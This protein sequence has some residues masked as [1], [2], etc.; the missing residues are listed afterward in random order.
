MKTKKILLL[1]VL[2]ATFLTSGI[3]ALAAAC[4]ACESS[5]VQAECTQRNEHM[6]N[7]TTSHT[8][9]Y[10]EGGV[11]KTEKCT[12]YLSEDRVSWVCPN[13]HGVV[14]TKIHHKETH[15]NSHCTN[16]DYYY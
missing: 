14:L 3:T 16:L 11:L 10:S 7:S 8:V 2:L 5:N 1:S 4:P 6:W 13:G 15:S 12:K 9:Q